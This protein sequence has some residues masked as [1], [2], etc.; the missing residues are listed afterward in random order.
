[1]PA[2][3]GSSAKSRRKL[4]LSVETGPKTE[5]PLAMPRRAAVRASS[6]AAAEAALLR[7]CT[8]PPERGIPELIAD[9]Q[10]LIQR[11]VSRV[12]TTE[13]DAK[14][15]KPT[16]D[17]TEAWLCPRRLSESICAV[18][19]QFARRQGFLEASPRS[20]KRSIAA[21]IL[22]IQGKLS[23]GCTRWTEDLE[24]MRDFAAHFHIVPHQ[25]HAYECMI[26]NAA[27]SRRPCV[28]RE[29]CV[30]VCVCVGVDVVEGPWR[31]LRRRGP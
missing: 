3:A 18:S 15:T 21:A 26:M 23:T 7:L 28:Q 16:D 27:Y 5:R 8:A 10:E 9:A 12:M 31:K 14:A 6:D 1:M 25:L 17:T 11:L 20:C 4:A 13:S 22:I 19:L 30:C 2:E 24:S 29:S